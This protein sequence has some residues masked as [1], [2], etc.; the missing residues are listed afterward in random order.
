MNNWDRA[1]TQG[2][3]HYRAG[4]TQPIDLYREAG[5]FTPFALCSIIKYAYRCLVRGVQD[6]DLVKIRHY[7]GLLRADRMDTEAIATNQFQGA[8]E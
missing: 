4:D 2:S 1:K 7:A 3:A 8:K 5:A 6:S